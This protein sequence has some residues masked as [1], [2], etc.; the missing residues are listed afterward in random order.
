M[1]WI[2]IHRLIDM[3]PNEGRNAPRQQLL[4]GIVARL[5]VLAM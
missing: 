2:K 4:E 1:S 5:L 3:Q